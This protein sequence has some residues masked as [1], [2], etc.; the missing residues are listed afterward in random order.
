MFDTSWINIGIYQAVNSSNRSV[1][2]STGVD[3]IEI[4]S[5]QKVPE[6][7]TIALF[8]SAT[9]VVVAFLAARARRRAASLASA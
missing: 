7:G 9:A 2:A 1:D 8:T 4:L 6:P 5:V 3:T